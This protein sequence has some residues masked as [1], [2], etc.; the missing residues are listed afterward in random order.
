MK[1]APGGYESVTDEPMSANRGA[2]SSGSEPLF[3]PLR[4]RFR[5][6]PG[7]GRAVLLFNRGATPVSITVDNDHLGYA[8]SMR[9]KVRDLWA[10]KAAGRWKGAI[11]ATV[12]PHG[13]AMFRITPSARPRSR[14]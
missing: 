7:G 13:V 1:V 8:S 9:A 4:S 10:H 3:L 2:N 11:E 14:G 12:E 5:Q 6:L